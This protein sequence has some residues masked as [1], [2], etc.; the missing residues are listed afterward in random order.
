MLALQTKYLQ[1][2]IEKYGI[3]ND[4][5]LLIFWNAP[6]PDQL[7]VNAD[8]NIDSQFIIIIERDGC[9]IT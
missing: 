3:I 7:I 6:N 9:Y 2:E 4:V 8:V 1:K 5:V